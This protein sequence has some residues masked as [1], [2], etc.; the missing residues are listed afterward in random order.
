MKDSLKVVLGII[1]IIVVLFLIGI[2]GV[3]FNRF[4][5]AA[6]EQT[7]TIIYKESQAKIEGDTR[8]LD[9]LVIQYETANSQAA[10]DVIK[11]TIRHRLSGIDRKKLPYDLNSR[12]DSILQQ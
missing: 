12:I 6:N 2:V 8:D 10:K 1:G 7:R 11:D 5:G 9:N 3:G 4:F